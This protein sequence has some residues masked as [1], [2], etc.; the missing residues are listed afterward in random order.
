MKTF[1]TAILALCV[2]ALPTWAQSD[3][4]ESERALPRMASL[5]SKLV[6]ARSGHG[7]RYPIEWVYKQK[8]APVEIIAEFDLWRQIRDWEGSET[9]VYKPML[10]SKRWI[11]LTKQ[12]LSNIYAKAEPE[13][14]IIAKVENGV[15]GQ[16][17]KCPKDTNFCLIKFASIEGWVEKGDLFGVYPNEIIN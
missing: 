10:S 17:E 14:K 11:K 15:I 8:N 6:N 1:L 16:V 9:W 5:R 3:G 12:G 7:T 13:S 2:F 4:T